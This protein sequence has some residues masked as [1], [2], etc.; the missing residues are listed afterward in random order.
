VNIVK[1][2]GGQSAKAPAPAQ[3]DFN[4]DDDIPF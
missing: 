4:K 1:E 3:A 2:E